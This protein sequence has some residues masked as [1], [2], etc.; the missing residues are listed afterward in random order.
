MRK[1]CLIPRHRYEDDTRLAGI[2]YL[3][4]VTD[5]LPHGNFQWIL[6]QFSRVC[7][8]RDSKI[9]IVPNMWRKTDW[10]TKS[11]QEQYLASHDLYVK[12]VLD[13][14]A[15]IVPHD[16]TRK[17]ALEVIQKVLRNR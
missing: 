15:K 5:V 2:I 9:A 16:D 7:E 13:S 14:G 6:E 4:K 10:G 12:A 17:S 3:H 8:V 1:P 11:N